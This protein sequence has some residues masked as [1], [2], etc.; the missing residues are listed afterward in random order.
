MKYW[1]KV[2][3][4][5]SGSK[6]ANDEEQIRSNKLKQQ[7]ELL[8]ILNSNWHPSYTTLTIQKKELPKIQ[9][10]IHQMIYVRMNET[11]FNRKPKPVRISFGLQKRWKKGGLTIQLIDSSLISM[12]SLLAEKGIKGKKLIQ[13][14]EAKRILTRISTI[15]CIPTFM[16]WRIQNQS[17]PWIGTH[18]KCINTIHKSVGNLQS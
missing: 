14:G 9:N 8:V 15:T 17:L 11:H 1:W 2:K 16:W 4:V 7:H 18:L 5:K 3:S 13:K 6:D 12:G 10:S